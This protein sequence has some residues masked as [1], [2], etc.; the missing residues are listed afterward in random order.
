MDHSLARRLRR[1]AIRQERRWRAHGLG[2]SHKPDE[3]APLRLTL[4]ELLNLH[5]EA[6][7]PVLVMVLSLFTLIPVGGAGWFVSFFIA[8]LGWSWAR[9]RERVALPGA[10][11]GFT[12]NELW[13]R[14]SLHALAWLYALADR[15]LSPRWQAWRH[16]STRGWWGAWIAV[17]AAII[18]LPLPFGNVLPSASLVLL[19]LGWLFR[20]G[21]ALAASTLAGAAA[22][23]YTLAF[24]QLAIDLVQRGWGWLIG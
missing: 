4:T 24:G 3:T 19:G 1:A 6:S 15:W 10:L 9:G 22:I 11:R 21:L 7:L 14:R 5:G 12:L 16:D 13:S 20:D 23:A 2:V 17:M 18:F 8:A